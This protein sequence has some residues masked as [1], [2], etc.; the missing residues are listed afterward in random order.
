[1]IDHN[2]CTRLE[3]NLAIYIFCNFGKC[4][5]LY[6]DAFDHI[7]SVKKYLIDVSFQVNELVI[8]FVSKLHSS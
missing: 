4:F 2:L 6:I 1:M 8:Q 3:M 7:F 5:S